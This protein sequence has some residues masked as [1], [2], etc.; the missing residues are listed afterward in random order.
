M[1]IQRQSRQVTSTDGARNEETVLAVAVQV[2]ACRRCLQRDTLLLDAIQ[3]ARN[4]L[5]ESLGSGRSQWSWGK[6]HS[7][8]H[9]LDQKPGNGGSELHGLN[10]LPRPG[11][12][13]LVDATGFDESRA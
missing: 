1:I 8:R 12:E 2:Q 10:P 3:A 7:I 4:E 9:P 11:D 5:G 13:Y 6:R